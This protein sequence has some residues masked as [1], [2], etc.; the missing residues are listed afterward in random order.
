MDILFPKEL[1]AH[2]PIDCIPR[3]LTS[4]SC[5]DLCW[6]FELINY[7]VSLG[8]WISPDNGVFLGVIILY[9]IIVLTGAV[10]GLFLNCLLNL[11]FGSSEK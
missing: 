5:G 4:I 7:F 2:Q 1:L 10:T 6:I 9:V 3:D 8:I 11:L